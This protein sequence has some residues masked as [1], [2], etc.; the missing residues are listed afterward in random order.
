MAKNR[1]KRRAV[2]QVPNRRLP[3]RMGSRYYQT[4][5]AGSSGL[6]KR[7]YRAVRMPLAGIVRP[8]VYQG[9]NQRPIVRPRP[10]QKV[11]QN[12]VLTQA[13]V[14]VQRRERKEVLFARDV[15]GHSGSSP[16]RNNHYRRTADSKVRC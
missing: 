7:P 16:G 5:F 8:R 2:T 10:L 1:N 4:S 13:R 11:F 14:C 15:A 9:I 12:P 3:L 6:I